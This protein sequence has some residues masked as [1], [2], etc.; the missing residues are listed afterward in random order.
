M[1]E[2]EK[3]LGIGLEPR[4][5]G[6]GAVCLRAIIIFVTTL[7]TVRLG[8]RRFMA[9]LTA[10]D[11]VLGFLL[12]SVLA[13]GINGSAPFLP[14]LVVGIVLVLLHRMMSVVAF[15]WHAFSGWVKGQPDTLVLDGKP[16]EKRLQ[17]HKISRQDLLEEAR[18]NG[19]IGELEKISTATLERNGK[20]SIIPGDG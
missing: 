4:D 20:I 2:I 9:R 1:E 5:L 18:L 15:H 6:V 7:I 3:L 16:D 8:H 17:K 19:R 10:F 12:A 13:R 11:T 14:T